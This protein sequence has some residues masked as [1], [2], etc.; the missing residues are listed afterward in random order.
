MLGRSWMGAILLLPM[1]CLL[2]TSSCSAPNSG[3]YPLIVRSDSIVLAWDPPVGGPSAVRSIASYRIYYRRHVASD[4]TS[5]WQ[6]LAQVPAV[7][8]PRLRVMHDD[9][10]DGEFDFAVSTVVLSGLES[11]LHTSLD[12]SAAPVGGWHVVWIGA[13]GGG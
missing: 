4:L 1:A 6:L 11:R 8:S 5:G 2:A 9:L 7:S 13:R 3:S 12:F 10:G